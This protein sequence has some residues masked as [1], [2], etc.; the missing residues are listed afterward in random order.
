MGKY[1]YRKITM[2]T[3]SEIESLLAE[4][5]TKRNALAAK[6]G[7]A[8]D[9]AQL[10]YDS[11][12][13]ALRLRTQQV[14]EFFTAS[15]NGQTFT[16]PSAVEDYIAAAQSDF[17]RKR[18]IRKDLA[19]EFNALFPEKEK[20]ESQLAAATDETTTVKDTEGT[21]NPSQSDQKTDDAYADPSRIPDPVQ[22]FDDGSSIQTFDDGSTL[23]TD[24]E[25]KTSS[26]ESTDSNWKCLDIQAASGLRVLPY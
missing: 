7:P 2:A 16:G 26:T 14:S 25:G 8:Q 18:D 12:Q 6:I 22:T 20:L 24:S 21:T 5:E 11:L 1:C 4:N 13:S 19:V 3:K 9:A 10:A 17:E 23:V 15:Y